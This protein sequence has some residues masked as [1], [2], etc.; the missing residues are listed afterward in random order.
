MPIN[1]IKNNFQL[2]TQCDHALPSSLLV[3]TYRS[4]FPELNVKRRSESVTED[5]IY[6]DTPDKNDGFTCAQLFVGNKTL[7]KDVHDVKS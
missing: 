4:P 5:T 2:S 1:T 6:S 3:K 7:L